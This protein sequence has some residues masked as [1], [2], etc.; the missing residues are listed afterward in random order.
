MNMKK[1]LTALMLCMVSIMS[2]AQFTFEETNKNNLEKVCGIYF[3]E[4]IYLNLDDST[5][6]YFIPGEYYLY[7]FGVDKTAPSYMFKLIFN[8]KQELVEFLSTVKH[9]Y[10]N[11]NDYRGQKITFQNNGETYKIHAPSSKMFAPYITLSNV[12]WLN[13][14]QHR[15]N[16]AGYVIGYIQSAVLMK[17]VNKSLLKY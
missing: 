16:E 7:D 1:I 13:G 4:A 5:F 9:I 14:R 11:N 12:V 8:S 6:I 3:N 15:G 10:D 2:F 17:K